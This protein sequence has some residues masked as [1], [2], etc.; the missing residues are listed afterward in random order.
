MRAEL[1]E[2]DRDRAVVRLKPSWLERL[3]GRRESLVELERREVGGW[4]T[5]GTGRYLSAVAHSGLIHDAID[6]V[7]VSALPAA[8]ARLRLPPPH[9][10]TVR[11]R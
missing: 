4:H 8:R 2:M 9:P 5:A 11:P 3:I 6:F 1:V 7:A 10:T